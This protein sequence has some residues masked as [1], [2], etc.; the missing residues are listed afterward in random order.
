MF[1]RNDPKLKFRRKELRHNKTK[2]EK[3]LW[4]SLRRKNL[5]YKFT[6]QYSIGPYIL[7][8]YCPKIR[9]AVE[10]DGA[11][12]SDKDSKLYDKEREKYLNSVNIKVIRFWN[13]EVEENIEKVL[14]RILKFIS[15]F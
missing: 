14:E 5:G 10:L 1:L 2:E 4:A 6:R 12:H 9:L 8:F 15:T 7:D 3:F 11:V 13:S